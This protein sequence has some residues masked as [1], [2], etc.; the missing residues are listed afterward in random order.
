MEE[1]RRERGHPPL[2]DPAPEEGWQEGAAQAPPEL[3]PPLHPPVHE[4]TRGWPGGG[5]A[6]GDPGRPTGV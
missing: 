5:G 4:G 6:V 1:E 3:A 2:R